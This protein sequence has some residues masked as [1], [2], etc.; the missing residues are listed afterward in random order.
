MDFDSL[1]KNLLAGKFNTYEEYLFDLQLIWDN[2]K[3]Y[4]RQGSDIFKLCERMEKMARREIQKFKSAHGLNGLVIPNTGA[5]RPLPPSRASKRSVTQRTAATADRE[6]NDVAM[7]AEDN[8][9]EYGE[10]ESNEV[11]RDMKL[12]FVN[13]IKKLTNAGLTSLVDKV[14][15]I[16]SQTISELPQEKIQIRVDDFEKTEFLQLV[17]HVDNLLV[18]E[19]PSKRQ[20]TH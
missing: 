15:E 10:Q 2:C 7:G 17:E 18:Q 19:L 9:Q 11:T 13:K 8:L 14:K 5:T 12:E 20:K 6:P 1:K 4:N 3:L 16:K